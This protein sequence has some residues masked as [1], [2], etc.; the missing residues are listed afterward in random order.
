LAFAGVALFATTW[1]SALQAVLVPRQRPPRAARWAVRATAGP[2]TALAQRLG[3]GQR[4][5]VMT[6]CGPL[7]MLAMFG[8]WLAGL[9]ASSA[10]LT[11]AIAGPGEPGPARVLRFG[12]GADDVAGKVVAL[13]TVVSVIVLIGLFMVH[14]SQLAGAYDRRERFTAR[15]AA[16]AAQPADAERILA[17]YVRPDSREL[18]SMFAQWTDWLADLRRT[19]ISFPVLGYLRPGNELCWLQAAVIVMDTA[20]LVEAAAPSWAEPYARALLKTGSGCF[21]RLCSGLGIVLAHPSVSLQGREQV[22]FEDTMRLATSAGLPA[23]RSSPDAWQVF[24]EWRTQYAP[25]AS[26]I[27]SKL[28]YRVPVP[29]SDDTRADD[30][31]IRIPTRPRRPHQ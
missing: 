8:A 14:L 17:T 28:L 11:A 1:S 3:P 12:Y 2:L 20:A 30:F 27:T 25:C 21:E 23:E 31:D 26:A 9:F 7:S 4:E 18:D 15:L 10:L 24:Q 6:M 22:G 19:H 16:Q 29:D 5:F 13:L